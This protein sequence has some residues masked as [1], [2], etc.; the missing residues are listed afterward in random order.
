MLSPVPWGHQAPLSLSQPELSGL[1]KGSCCQWSHLGG[2]RQHLLCLS[3]WRL[4]SPPLPLPCFAGAVLLF[5]TPLAVH[6]HGS[7]CQRLLLQSPSGLGPLAFTFLWQW[8][9]SHAHTAQPVWLPLAWKICHHLMSAQDFAEPRTKMWI[10][11]FIYLF[12]KRN[13]LHF[14]NLNLCQLRNSCRYKFVI[15]M[16]LILITQSFRS[17]ILTR[18]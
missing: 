9:S 13:P 7:T 1:A 5:H 14:T 6:P 4:A 18:S 15:Q 2:V 11:R 16:G 17:C 3:L 10:R 12:F 8:I